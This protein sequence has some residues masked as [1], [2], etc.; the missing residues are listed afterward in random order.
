LPR[1]RL[2]ILVAFCM[3][4]AGSSIV[5]LIVNSAAWSTIITTLIAVVGIAVTLVQWLFPLP[6]HL[7]PGGDASHARLSTHSVNVA[8]PLHDDDDK[9]HT[10]ISSIQTRPL[11]LSTT[12]RP[13]SLS[14]EGVPPPTDP[15]TIQQREGVVEAI[16]VKLTQPET[17]ALVLTGI[18]GVGKSTLAALVYHYAESQRL[19][20]RG[21]FK[22]EA[23]WLTIDSSTVTM[24][25]LVGTICH[26]LNVP[27]PELSN[28]A[29]QNQAATLFNT[30][31]TVDEARLIVLDQFEN[32]LDWQ[33]GRVVPGRPGIGEWLDAINSRL[34]RCRILLTSRIWPQGTRNYAPTYMQEYP[35]SGLAL[36]EGCE[37][38]QKLGIQAPEEQLQR[39]VELCEGHAYALTLLA[40][41]LRNRRLRL[42]MFFRDVTYSQLWT[43]NVARNF[44]D[45][46]YMQQLDKLQQQLL[47]AF[48][49]YREP[50]PIEAALAVIDSSN[51]LA[52]VSVQMA[53]DTLLGQHLLQ[54]GGDAQYQLH[55][56]VKGYAD[57]HF[58]SASRAANI[59]ARKDAHA[60]AAFYYQQHASY[61]PR[62]LRR[63]RQDVEPLLEAIWQYCQAEQWQKAYAI[64]EQEGLHTDL[65]RWGNAV[66]T[67]DLYSLLLPIERWCHANEQ[68]T[69]IYDDLGLI[70]RLAGQLEQ[71]RVC[72]ETALA[73]CRQT[74]NRREE[75][76]ALNHMGRWYADTGHKVPALAYYEDALK[77]HRE[78]H[79]LGGECTAL[80][81][82]GWA[83]YD[84]DRMDLARQKYEEA[85]ALR[86]TMQDRKGEASALNSLS[87]VYEY[88]GQN[89]VA[90]E[91]LRQ[92]LTIC[93]EI[94]DRPGEGW[95]LNNLGRAYYSSIL[96]TDLRD[97]EN[98]T[99]STVPLDVDDSNQAMSKMSS[100]HRA[101]P[102]GQ[103]GPDGFA[104]GQQIE[105]QECYE[106]ALR[107]RHEIGDR[108]GEGA[109]LSNLAVLLT[110]MGEYTRAGECYD[111]ALVFR[112]EVGDRNGEGKT[113]NYVGQF[114][115]QQ[116]Q[117][118][119]AL[120]Y[121]KQACKIHREL[122][123]AK[124]QAEV[125][126]NLAS[127]YSHLSHY[128][129]ALACLFLAEEKFV[130][131]QQAGSD[132]QDRLEQVEGAK[133]DLQQQ[134]TVAQWPQVFASVESH[135]TETV[136][137]L[138]EKEEP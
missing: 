63:S 47:L 82:I 65:L 59:Q 4:V 9:N 12:N 15:R 55:A 87:R 124:R 103:A 34:C 89:D 94:G 56:I 30:L 78:V 13:P 72:F 11:Q 91:T 70:Y 60:R 18:A 138:L 58:A 52:S 61:P 69:R 83:Y 95:T 107:I 128:E 137:E 51:V 125:L 32:L 20:D 28:L 113:L 37:L 48:A 106:A 134:I 129:Q 10:A 3:L 126:Y 46:I 27:L 119:Q 45:H 7:S 2:L 108:R 112:R 120:P 118:I 1:K 25:D 24:T 84:V 135:Y 71:A 14:I 57:E 23:L 96:Q 8:H 79:D 49:V 88:L 101:S 54:S 16:Y 104:S 29:P 123:H 97:G 114:Y 109:T 130:Q 26:A 100:S 35:V 127:S 36:T 62:A 133:D 53:L 90:C 111:R 40:A 75:A 132:V 121:F 80:T 17:T 73:L 44:L 122:N 66:E 92:A 102:G 115:A 116:G 85:L 22:A 86:R 136:E 105:A 74:H 64:I 117:H 41:L 81:N 31:N 98:L 38:L 50:V 19:A 99:S 93:R 43:G 5:A 77:I 39:A 131:A 68:I 110:S 42:E 67:L 6:S 76:W 21:P 33:N